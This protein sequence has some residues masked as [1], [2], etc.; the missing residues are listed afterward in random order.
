MAAMLKT[1]RNAQQAP[2]GEEE[3]APV[4]HSCKD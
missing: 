4:L 1:L 2:P 3:E